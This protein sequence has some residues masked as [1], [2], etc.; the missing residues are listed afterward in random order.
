MYWILN[1]L[2]DVSNWYKMQYKQPIGTI[3]STTADMLNCVSLFQ[4]GDGSGQLDGNRAL[5]G[6]RSR[7]QL[8]S[9]AILF[10][11]AEELHRDRALFSAKCKTQLE[12]DISGTRGTPYPHKRQPIY[13]NDSKRLP[14]FCVKNLDDKSNQP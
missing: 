4:G 2:A 9:S 1:R 14:I 10:Q 5:T 6:A 7:T 13:C 3:N 11:R 12:P 8:K